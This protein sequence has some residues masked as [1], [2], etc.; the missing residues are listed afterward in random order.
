M[1]RLVRDEAVEPLRASMNARARRHRHIHTAHMHIAASAQP[2]PRRKRL[3]YSPRSNQQGPHARPC[4]AVCLRVADWGVSHIGK[5][6][7]R[8]HAT[9][10]INS[11]AHLTHYLPGFAH[12]LA[13]YTS[14][15]SRAGARGPRASRV[16]LRSLRVQ[17]WVLKLLASTCVSILLCL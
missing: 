15:L 3:S 7:R 9:S 4:A 16:G 13:D 1:D 10:T 12:Y 17:G 11:L 8:R 6:S 2:G 14:A 5:T